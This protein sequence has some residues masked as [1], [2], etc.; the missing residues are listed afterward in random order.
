MGNT[1][2]QAPQQPASAAAAPAA[3]APATPEQPQAG[4]SPNPTPLGQEP[5]ETR[6]PD[7]YESEI[8]RLREENAKYRRT[9][10]ELKQQQIQQLPENERLQ[11]EL[12]ELRVEKARLESERRQATFVSTAA[13]Y[14]AINPD[15]VARLVDSEEKDVDGAIRFLKKE[16]PYL[17]QTAAPRPV[18]VNAG[19]GTGTVPEEKLTMS[20]LIRRRAKM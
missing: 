18:N 11:K 13:R 7:S 9:A 2:G 5:K 12:E 14:G 6:D 8:R 3:A 19:A 1:E 16:N 20:E 15:V 4:S 17:F 10:A